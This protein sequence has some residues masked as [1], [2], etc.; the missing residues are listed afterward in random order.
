MKESSIKHDLWECAELEETRVRRSECL[1]PNVIHLQQRLAGLDPNS[2]NDVAA[3][4][5][6]LPSELVD[7]LQK[8]I[9]D[10]EYEAAEMKERIEKLNSQS[11]QDEGRMRS[12]AVKIERL[13]DDIAFLSDQTSADLL[14]FQEK[15]KLSS[16]TAKERNREIAEIRRKR[17]RAEMETRRTK[18]EIE[19]L[20]KISKRVHG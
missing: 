11:A 19:R 16:V 2:L 3:T 10:F 9:D 1:N 4:I 18:M 13:K 14:A 8:Y 12:I 17:E 20:R 6:N 5:S 7:A 15:M